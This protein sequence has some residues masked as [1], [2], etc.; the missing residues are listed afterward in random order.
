MDA[1]CLDELLSKCPIV[2]IEDNIPQ[3]KSDKKLVSVCYSNPH[4]P[5]LNF[6]TIA[7]VEKQ[8]PSQ[9]YTVKNWKVRTLSQDSNK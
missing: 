9:F 3:P 6:S 5:S 8:S 4:D 1:D 2:I 7:T